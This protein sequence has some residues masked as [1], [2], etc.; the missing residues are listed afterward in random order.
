MQI[1]LEN[2]QRFH[3]IVLHTQWKYVDVV[4]YNSIM[5]SRLHL[6]TGRNPTGLT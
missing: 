4:V 5:I 2:L 3:I 6:Y 1:N